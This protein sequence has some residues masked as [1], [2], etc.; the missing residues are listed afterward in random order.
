[1]DRVN[2]GNA[3]IAGMNKDLKL[4]GLQF[5]IAVAVFYPTYMV[6]EILSNPILRF[7]QAN[8]VLAGSMV[9]WGFITLLTGFVVDNYTDLV[10]LRVFLGLTEGFLVPCAVW[11]ITLWYPKEY[12]VVRMA[13]FSAAPTLAGGFGGLIARGC[14]SITHATIPGWAF[15]F[16]IE[17]AVTMITGFA[18]IFLLPSSLEAAKFLDVRQR[19]VW[20]QR[21]HKDRGMSVENNS[22]HHILAAFTDL[23][24]FLVG[25]Q[26][27]CEGTQHF[28]QS[29]LLI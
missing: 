7:T 11:Y 23:K 28:V 1:M 21:L 8:Y 25:L 13:L 9:A 6:V 18:A 24:V 5:N 16:V 3:A 17:G 15:I 19:M 20:A 26:T 4:V 12:W 10:I 22:R 29:H 14:S 27:L 2:L